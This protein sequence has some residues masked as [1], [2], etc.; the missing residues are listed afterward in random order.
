M[1][2]K[3]NVKTIADLVREAGLIHGNRAFVRYEKEDHIK[4]MSFGNF[5]ELCKA[6]AGWTEEKNKENGYQVRIG[7]FGGSS[8]P[9]LTALFGVMSNGNVAAPL[10]IQ[11]NMVSLSDCINRAD[12][13]YLFYD[14]EYNE[15]AESVKQLCP[16]LKGVICLQNRK[17][18]YC[19]QNIW[20]EYA[21]GELKTEIDPKTCAM[22][23]FTS[24]TTG[25]AKGV[26]LSHENL[27]DNTFSTEFDKH[28]PDEVCLNVLPVHHVFCIHGDF[29]LTL[30]DGNVICL[31]QDM[32]KL[33]SHLQLFQPTTIATVPMMAKSLYNKIAILQKQYP[34][35]SIEEI[36]T[37]VFGNRIK[38]IACGGGYLAPDLAAH[39]REMGILIGQGYGM[40]E[41]SPK[42]SAADFSRPDKAASVGKIVG[43]C[44]VRIVDGEIQVKSPSVMMGYYKDPEET[45]KS[46]T[47]DGWLRTGDMGYFDEE[48]FLFFTGRCKNLIVLSNGENVAPEQ[49][50]NLFEDENLIEDILVYGED[51]KICAEVY[52]NL[53]LAK[54]LGMENLEKVVTEIVQKHN[55]DLPS[56]KRILQT[57]VR[58]IPF[59]KTASKKIIREK[60]F[61]QKAKQT[62]EKSNFKKPETERQQIMFDCVAESLGHHNFGIET[63]LFE[64]GI[65]SL[66]CVMLLSA[67]YDKMQ[68]S[69][70]LQELSEHPTITSL[71]L[72]AM[73]KQASQ[74]DYST[75]EVYPLTG[76]QTYFGYILRGNTTSNLPFLFRLDTS[77]DLEKL[78]HAVEQV[79]EI[80]P[81]M[82]AVIQPMENGALATFR[83]DDK[84]IDIP[85]IELSDREWENTKEHLLQ[86]FMYTEN[87]P[88]FHVGIYKTESSAYLFFDLA[89]IVG[90]GMS[91]NIIFEDINA[92]YKGNMPRK[93]TY[94]LYEYALDEMDRKQRGIREECIQYFQKQMEN[95][96]ITRSILARKDSTDLE[97]GI[98]GAIQK[99]FIGL[100]RKKVQSFCKKYNVSENVFFLTAFSYCVSV[101]SN[102]DDIVVSS[103]H[104]GR[105]DSRWHRVVGPLYRTYYHRYTRVPHETVPEL[106]YKSANQILKT[107][108]KP[109]SNIRADEMFFQYQGEIMNIH[110]IGDAPAE[111]IRLNL[112]ATPF[113]LQVMANT[114]GYFYELRYWENRYDRKQLEIFMNCYKSILQAMMVEK[115]VRRLKYYIDTEDKPFDFYTEAGKINAEAGYD[116]IPNVSPDTR[117]KAYVF[118]IRFQK[119]PF[120][121]WGDLYIMDY[122]T[123]DYVDKVA[124]P[125]EDGMMYQ[126]GRVARITQDGRLEFLEDA[127]R[128]VML[129]TLRGRTYVDLLQVEKVL[130][131]CE[132]V[133]KVQAYTYYGGDNVLLVGADVAGVEEKDFERIKAY[134][135][136]RLYP[137][138]VPTRLVCS[139]YRDENLLTI[140]KSH[141]DVNCCDREAFKVTSRIHGDDAIIR[142]QAYVANKT[143]NQTVHFVLKDA[144]DNI[145]AET[146]KA[147]KANDAKD[148][149]EH[150]ALIDLEQDIRKVRRW[151]DNKQPYHYTA[152]AELVED[153]VIVDSV[154]TYF[155]C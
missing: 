91:I 86:P 115:S 24:G 143:E 34:D 37:W 154:S 131:A 128:T 129:E 155:K 8:R 137:A 107:M 125:Y 104:S 150:I 146:C 25:K 96:K 67:L 6:V 145:V 58:Y 50:E 141:F 142:L 45:A 102:E 109:V 85:I 93:Q 76:T 27:I 94:T 64:A 39:Y 97:R 118:D 123:K 110:E 41:C 74:V 153:G 99:D 121:G 151:D 127:G 124:S 101:F 108:D 116:L 78:K 30:K 12:L 53:Q 120:G 87:E 75:R 133:T 135:A 119:K 44:E 144:S 21:D 9:F 134:A 16:N 62:E 82:K 105:T 51:D 11:F 56:Y 77:V 4:E 1:L 136:E 112:D 95:L 60:Y 61:A 29:L 19:V 47:E 111:I 140:K 57:H 72:F 130:C 48:G 3:E 63:D 122:P 90:D 73:E 49:L 40:T 20:N 83:K 43:G 7:I 2:N 92:V 106:L 70:S 59:E 15:L 68:I 35:K 23:L 66:G 79:F 32:M 103:T 33:G 65:D 81:E 36:K 147:E 88:L 113:H 5:Y 80:H 98:T 13:D 139:V 52:P 132:G 149:A 55:Q 54:T 17:H 114:N 28:E 117:V 38:K 148:L 22:V 71:D 100:S 126:T 18:V 69:I 152:V 10:D 14:W 31:N 138:W 26:M 46:I 89:H 42:I 84:V